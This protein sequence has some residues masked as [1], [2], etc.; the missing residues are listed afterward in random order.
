MK[1]NLPFQTNRV[2]YIQQP[3][4]QTPNFFGMYFQHCV[5]IRE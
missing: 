1:K 5:D 4:S 2:E 3:H